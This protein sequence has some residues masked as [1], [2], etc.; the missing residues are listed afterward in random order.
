MS[1]RLFT[2]IIIVFITACADNNPEYAAS[3]SYDI[4][5]EEA[6]REQPSAAESPEIPEINEQ[7]IDIQKKIIKEGEIRMEVGTLATAKK[8][9]DVLVSQYKAYYSKEDF[10]DS[11]YE[12]VYSLVVR[13][14][15]NSYENF[16]SALEAGNGKI[17]YKN[18]EA[19]DVTEQYLDINTRLENKRTYV[20][21]YRNI[22]QRATTI[23]E[24]LEVEQYIRKLEEEIESAEG[25]LRYLADRATYS[26]LTLIVTQQKQYTPTFAKEDM[27][28]Y[29]LKEAI[30]S[31]WEIFVG[32]FL[33]I[34][35]LWPF[36]L[37][38]IAILFVWRKRKKKT[39]Q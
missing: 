16:I 34:M 15:N 12:S 22:L 27:F 30:A 24:I 13:I 1:T 35:H 11:N 36:I 28:F 5:M 19:R 8:S 10:H 39:D 6:M 23:K 37:L 14:P 32:F 31:G 38:I 26:T 21:H 25:R 29:R 4:G 7:T 20:K 18:I 2:F 3:Y 9:I 33:A 17:T